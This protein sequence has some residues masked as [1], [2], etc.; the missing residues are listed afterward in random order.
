VSHDTLPWVLLRGL[1]RE[2]RHWGNFPAQ[3]REVQPGAPVIA[4][5]LPGNGALQ[6]QRSPA[7]VSAMAVHC[8]AALQALGVAPPYRVLA[9]SLGAMVAVAWAHAQP[10]ELA[11]AVLINTS[12]RPFGAFHRRLRPSQYPTLLRL[13]LIAADAAEWERSILALTSRRCFGAAES[14]ALLGAWTA[15]R[16]ECPVSRANALRQLLAAARFRA[17]QPR[18]PVP[19]L[20]LASARDALV[21]PQCSRRLAQ[22]WALPIAEHPTAGH[23]LP[24]DDGP[25]VA[26]QVEQFVCTSKAP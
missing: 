7:S 9:M 15:W 4:L 12:L 2:A 26:Q 16:L 6:A 24:L 25:W 14:D 3:L 20:V 13:A 8:R 1:T 21:D 10:R 17:P 18:P 19:L 11:A 22:A 23:D 5:D